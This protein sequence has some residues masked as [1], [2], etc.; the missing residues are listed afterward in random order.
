M[1]YDVLLLASVGCTQHECF[2]QEEFV[3]FRQPS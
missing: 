2:E 3:E 1:S